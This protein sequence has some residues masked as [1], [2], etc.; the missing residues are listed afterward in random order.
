MLHITR[1]ALSCLPFV[2]ATKT[3]TR[4]SLARLMMF[5]RD[6]IKSVTG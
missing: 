1:L 4:N 2:A 6:N 3:I 5:S